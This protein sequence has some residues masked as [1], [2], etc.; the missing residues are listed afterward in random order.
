LF[1]RAISKEINVKGERGKYGNREIGKLGIWGE[2][3]KGI[4]V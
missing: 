2:G 4:K 1:L 3:Y